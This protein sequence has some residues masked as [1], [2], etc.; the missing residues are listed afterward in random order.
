[1]TIQIICV[2]S[3]VS[4]LQGSGSRHLHLFP[5]FLLFRLLLVFIYL[6]TKQE[7]QD[8]S[9]NPTITDSQGSPIQSYSSLRPLISNGLNWNN[10]IGLLSIVLN[11]THM[12]LSLSLLLTKLG[13]LSP[14]YFIHTKVLCLQ[15]AMLG[16]SKQPICQVVLSAIHLLFAPVQ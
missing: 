10:C 9:Q 2:I 5:F 11:C 6:L 1:M 7:D 14:W 8:Q 4:A 3:V 15:K 13:H 12:L 16:S